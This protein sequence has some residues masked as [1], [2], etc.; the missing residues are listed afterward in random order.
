[1]RFWM[2]NTCCSSFRQGSLFQAS[3]VGSTG[4]V[5]LSCGAFLS[6]IVL[7]LYLPYNR[8]HVSLSSSFP[9][10]ICFLD[11]LSTACIGWHLLTVSTTGESIA[12]VI[13]FRV[14]VWRCFRPALYAELLASENKSRDETLVFVA[15]WGREPPFAF[16]FLGR[17]R[18]PREPVLVNDASNVHSIFSLLREYLAMAAS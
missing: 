17:L 3:L 18:S 4:I 8:V 16:P 11:N 13:P 2:R 12:V 14:F 7:T 10:G 15:S 1:M 9:R 5:R 6:A